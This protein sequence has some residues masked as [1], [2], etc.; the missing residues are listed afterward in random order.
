M[1]LN[2]RKYSRKFKAVVFPMF[3]FI[4][5]VEYNLTITT[6][7][8]TKTPRNPNITIDKPS[9]ISD[10]GQSKV[11]VQAMLNCTDGDIFKLLRMF[12]IELYSCA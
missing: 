8:P 2:L 11:F 7:K 4:F 3:F 5:F 9:E 6:E 1:E 12:L 10:W